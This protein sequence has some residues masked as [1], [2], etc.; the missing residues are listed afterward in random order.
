MYKTAETFV[1]FVHWCSYRSDDV[2]SLTANGSTN[3]CWVNGR[4]ILATQRQAITGLLILKFLT[5]LERVVSTSSPKR[6]RWLKTEVEK[7]M[8]VKMKIQLLIK[9]WSKTIGPHLLLFFTACSVYC[10]LSPPLTSSPRVKIP[11]VLMSLCWY[12]T[13]H[14]LQ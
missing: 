8:D 7:L 2:R 4:T 1:S 13:V 10:A 3:I 6:L 11:L 14:G 12:T 9:Q 5:E